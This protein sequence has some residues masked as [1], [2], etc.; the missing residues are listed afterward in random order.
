MKIKQGASIQGIHPC[1]RKALIEC[2]RVMR[3][4]GV[5]FVITSGLDG[6]HSAGSLHY[7]GFAIDVRTREL[8]IYLNRAYNDIKNS[9]PEFDVVLESNHIHIE[10][11]K[12]FEVIYGS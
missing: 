5:P 8:G 2:D 10:N 4:Y 7:Y 9:L 6:T 3:K 12:Q 11:E 1:M